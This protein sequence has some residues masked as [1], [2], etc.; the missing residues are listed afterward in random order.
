MKKIFAGAAMLLIMAPSAFAQT[1]PGGTS[2]GT[3][4]AEPAAPPYHFRDLRTAVVIRNGNNLA[5]EPGQNDL[6]APTTLTCRSAAGC[7]LSIA[8]AIDISQSTNNLYVVCTLVDGSPAR[9]QCL[10]HMYF[11]TSTLQ[12]VSVSQGRHVVETRFLDQG[13]A[14]VIGSWQVNYTLY[15]NEQ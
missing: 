14:G 2:Q 9:P 13:Q 7:E 3:A 10:N 12:S 1:V 5:V 4:P 11:E 8:A 6:G 15:E